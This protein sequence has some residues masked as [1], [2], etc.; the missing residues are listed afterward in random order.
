MSFQLNDQQESIVDSIAKLTTDFDDDYWFDRD[1]TGD[2]PVEFHKAMADGGW[3]GIAMP[4]E[5][6]G[7]NLGVTEAALMMHQIG[8]SPGA[9]SACSAIH[10]NIF[11][12]HPIVVFGNDEQKQRWLPDLIQGKLLTCFGVTEPDAGLNTTKLKTRAERSGNGYIVNGKKIW[13]TTAQEASKILLLARTTAV[14]NCKSPTDGLSLF[15]T[16]LDRDY[17]DIREIEKMGRKSVDSNEVFFDGLPVPLEDRIGEE[18]MGFRYILHSLN[19]ERIL[20][21]MEAVGI[22]QNALARAVKYAQEREVF[23]RPIGQNQSIQHPLAEDWMA[24]EAAYL[25]GLKAG[26]LYDNEMPCGAEANA[27]KYLGAEAGFK[28]ATNAVMTH[29][30][31]GYAKEF[32]VERLLR[33]SLLPRIA[34]VSPQMILNYIAERVLHLP[35]SY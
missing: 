18:G 32:H 20:I 12:P 30:G 6:G 33:E 34:P 35:K 27:T 11:G 1:H 28:A 4:E 23:D 31:M 7:A 26:Y 14:E 22:G 25:M 17:C 16:D 21:G 19:P 15:Y 5:Y 24:L 9:M 29:G 10:I 3:L 8:K 13:T 2:F